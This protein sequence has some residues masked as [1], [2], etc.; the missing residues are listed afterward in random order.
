MAGTNGNFPTSLPVLDGKS[1]WERWNTQ[2]LVIFGFQD[3]LEMVTSGYA[4]L[5]AE[6]STEH[7]ELKKKDM[8]A[9]FIIHKCVNPANFEKIAAA[10]TS[11]EVWE[12]LNKSY[13][14]VAKLKKVKLQTLRR[15]YEALRMEKS[16][17]ISKF[18]TRLQTLSNQMKANG[19]V[20]ND[21]ILV[22]K[23]L[24]S[25]TTRFDHI[26]T[27]IDKSKDLETI[28]I[29][30]LQGSLEAHEMRLNL[31][32]S[33]RETEQ[34]L[35][36]RGSTSKKKWGSNSKTSKEKN[37]KNKV[38]TLI[39]GKQTESKSNSRTGF[40]VLSGFFSEDVLNV[41]AEFL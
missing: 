1:D 18:F 12:I 34:A 20:M 29:E 28:K 14:G 13:D 41:K 35:Y 26:V 19:E 30:E 32:D 10:K 17:T 7:K 23:V 24:R 25:L 27:T 31:R 21:Q 2:M 39:F 33:E 6:Q 8:R 11:K 5:P 40:R 37:W 22:E 16:E 3:V 38:F 9:L 15:Q 4:A 36:V